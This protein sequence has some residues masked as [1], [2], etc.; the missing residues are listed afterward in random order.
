MKLA[1]QIVGGCAL[2]VA[3]GLLLGAP[4]LQAQNQDRR[5]QGNFDPQQMRQRMLDRIRSQFEVKED[6]EWKVISERI[7]KVMEA[8]RAVDGLGGSG[9]PGG[10]G[11]PPPF[12]A[13]QRGPGGSSAQGN[14]APPE[15]RSPGDP[16]EPDSGGPGPDGPGGPP[17][18]AGAFD[19]PGGAGGPP[20][21]NRPAEPELEALRNAL[22]SKAPAA[23]I[24]AKLAQLRDARKQKEAG[25]EK[26]RE[27]LRQLLSARQEAVAVTLGLLK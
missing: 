27:E 26:A 13:S 23:E 18:S 17:G 12:A 11:G 19:G 24:K 1:S 10:F 15:P 21:F 22:E 25:L 3:A 4:N 16:G 9:G 8:R 14:N 5:P 6:A 7:G 2:G 20:G